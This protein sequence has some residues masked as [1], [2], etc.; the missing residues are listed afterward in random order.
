MARD[1]KLKYP[2]IAVNDA[3]TKSDFDNVYGT[4]QSALDGVIRATNILFSGK[5]VVIAGSCHCGRGLT[6]RAS[7]R[8]ANVI[9]T[10][11]GSDK[12]AARQDG[13]L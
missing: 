6:S 3:E 1:G 4:G 8:G 13:R 5:S 2:I 9:V 12:G 10:V 11:N 7:S